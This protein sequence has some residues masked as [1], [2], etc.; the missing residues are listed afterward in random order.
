MNV[1][2][3]PARNFSSANWIWPFCWATVSNVGLATL[4]RVLTSIQPNTTKCAF[5]C[6]V[7]RCLRGVHARAMNC[8]SAANMWRRCARWCATHFRKA[9]DEWR[10]YPNAQRLKKKNTDLTQKYLGVTERM[11]WGLGMCARLKM[12]VKKTMKRSRSSAPV[13][14]INATCVTTSK[15]MISNPE[16]QR[17]TVCFLHIQLMVTILAFRRYIR[18]TPK[19][20]SNSQGRRQILNLEI[21]PIDNAEP[22]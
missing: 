2:K 15:E 9:N 10:L 3:M 12:C 20:I 6:I 21:N 14:T 18:L 13:H 7:W 19:F 16:E 8:L 17:D 5:G 11:F 4:R 22:C 1:E